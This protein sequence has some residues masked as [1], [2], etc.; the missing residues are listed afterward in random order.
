MLNLPPFI[1]R[2]KGKGYL[3]FKILTLF[4]KTCSIVVF[5]CFY[6]RYPE[7]V[8]SVRPVQFRYFFSPFSKMFGSEY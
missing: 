2:N 1:L 3:R 6:I 7:T 4:G 5:K 8:Q